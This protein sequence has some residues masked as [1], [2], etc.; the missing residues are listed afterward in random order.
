MI[1]K[2]TSRKKL[3]EL[4][5]QLFLSST[6][7]VSKVAKGTVVDST[8]HG[9]SA[10][11][12]RILKDIAVLESNIFPE[13]AF[14]TFLDNIALRNGIPS[15]FTQL[16]SSTYIRLFGDVGTAYISGTHQFTEIGRASCR[17]RV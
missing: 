6:D 13:S 11:S 3:K 9:I 16:G 4:F 14:G 2:P 12:Q 10:L 17:E 5:L 8:A 7:K 15:R 1:T